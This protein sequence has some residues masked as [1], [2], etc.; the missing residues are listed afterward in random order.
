MLTEIC[1]LISTS[2]FKNTVKN[3]TIYYAAPRIS[4]TLQ[5]FVEFWVVLGKRHRGREVDVV[6]GISLKNGGDETGQ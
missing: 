2:D 6:E 3:L 1:V 4:I 5:T